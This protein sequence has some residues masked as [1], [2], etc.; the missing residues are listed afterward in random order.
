MLGSGEHDMNV[1]D[2]AGNFA[3]ALNVSTDKMMG[4]F[5]KVGAGVDDAVAAIVAKGD[6]ATTQERLV[7]AAMD[8][9]AVSA[10]AAPEPF[11]KGVD[12]VFD[13]AWSALLVVL[14]N[15]DVAAMSV[16]F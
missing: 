10:R 1:M 4:L 6:D 11:G 16:L 9:S 2:Y 7:L 5:L 8:L 3:A 14:P 13:T 12:V 15:I